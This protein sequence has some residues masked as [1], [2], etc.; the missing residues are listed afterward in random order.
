MESVDWNE[1]YSVNQNGECWLSFY[2]IILKSSTN[3]KINRI[4]E[5]IKLTQVLK[6]M[7]VEFFLLFLN[8]TKMAKIADGHAI[9]CKEAS[10]SSMK[11]VLVKN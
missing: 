9:S 11:D 1:R 5:N 10:W 7:L 2:E 8:V 4:S 6:Y 3:I